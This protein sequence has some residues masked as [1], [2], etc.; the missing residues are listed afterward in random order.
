MT[1]IYDPRVFT[2]G[3]WR[4]AAGCATYSYRPDFQRTRARPSKLYWGA[5]LAAMTLL[6]RQRGYA[7]VGINSAGNNALYF[8]SD[9][10][11]SRFQVL[12]AEQ[13]YAPSSYRE[14]RDLIRNEAK[15]GSSAEPPTS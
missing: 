6:A 2:T 5:S 9:L 10:I 12:S 8:R 11:D 14:S 15:P 13:D 1:Q 3:L 4:E 7:L